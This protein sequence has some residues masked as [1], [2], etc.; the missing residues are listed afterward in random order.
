MKVLYNICIQFYYCIIYLTSIFSNKSRLWIKGRRHIFS[1]LEK[2]RDEKNIVWFHCSSL[3]E[4]E[5]GRS[6]IEL[7]KQKHPNH[8]LLLTFFSP[9][10]FEI[11]K[12]YKVVDWV[13]Y[14]PLDTKF[15]AKN[16]VEIVNPTKVIFIKYDFWF[17]YISEIHKKEI[18][19]YFISSIFRKDQ[20]F[21]KF[22][23]FAK[24]LK[25]VTHFFV[26]D[27]L[28]KSLLSSIGINKVTVS[29]DSRFDTVIKR[30]NSSDGNL[31][32]SDF[33]KGLPTII[34]GSTWSK[35]EDIISRF[36]KKNSQYN[37][38]IAPHEIENDNIISLQKKT[39]ALLYS[40]LEKNPI[41]SSNVIIID[42]IGL[43]S[44]IY[45]Y[46]DIA[47][48]GG[49]FGKGIHNIL[50]P[51]SYGLPIIFGP[52]YFKFKEAHDLI[53][54]RAAIS[55]NDFKEF[56]S[57]INYFSQYDKNLSKNYV[58]E[59]GGATDLIIKKI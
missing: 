50:E 33:V 28:S 6:V 18:P 27:E 19:L 52:N 30:S 9:S 44:S 3:G 22:D 4:F 1:E 12:N 49:G 5:Q 16:F 36:I 53:S 59:K 40:K 31:V 46:A 2:L 17:N 13:F 41:K 20:I 8:K 48:V 55:I 57:A 29:G 51:A 39:G 21:F 37:Y 38:I 14:L 45:Q 56:S 11:R 35:D 32:I 42:N 26:Q 10:G 15:N 7:Y 47:Y 54:L 23:W 24:Q 25:K 58:L 34:F 43:L